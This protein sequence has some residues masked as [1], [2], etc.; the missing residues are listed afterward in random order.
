MD[1][2]GSP[3]PKVA[4]DNIREAKALSAGK[5]VLAMAVA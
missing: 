3:A 4:R 2:S 1:A 5:K